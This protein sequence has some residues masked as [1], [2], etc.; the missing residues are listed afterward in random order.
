MNLK[1]AIAAYVKAHK[2]IAVLLLSLVALTG[3]ER[4]HQHMK[5]ATFDPRTGIIEWRETCSVAYLSGDTQGKLDKLRISNGKTQSIGVTGAQGQSDLENVR[6]IA[7]D[8]SKVAAQS[9]IKAFV[10]GL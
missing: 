9:L 8:L 3:C 10:P 5:S 4:V 1:N 2:P 6:G 7:D